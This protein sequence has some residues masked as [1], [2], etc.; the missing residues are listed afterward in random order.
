M[1]LDAALFMFFAWGFTLGLLAYCLI[2]LS[3]SSNHDSDKRE[4]TSSD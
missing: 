4:D 2:K 1:N 3:Y